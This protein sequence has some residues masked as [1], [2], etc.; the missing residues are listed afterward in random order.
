MNSFLETL[1]NLGPTRLAIMG[2]IMLTLITFL[3]FI[4][5]RVSSPDFNLLYGDLS[6]GDQTAI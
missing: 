3:I 2:G 5:M 1:K 6:S 4:S